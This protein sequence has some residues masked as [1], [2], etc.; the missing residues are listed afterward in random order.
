MSCPKKP[1]SRLESLPR[2]RGSDRRTLSTR[3]AI[4]CLSSSGK[5]PYLDLLYRSLAAAGVPAGPHAQLRLRWLLAHRESVRHLHV[6]WPEGLY[7]LRRGPTT[8]KPLLSWAKLTLLE[9]RLRMARVLGYRVIWTIHQ[10]YPHGEVRRIDRVAARLL[11]RHAALLVAHDPE[12]AA[13]ARAELGQGSQ[14]IE[15]VQHGSYVGVYPPGKPREAM[16]TALGVDARAVVFLCFGELREN[17]DVDVLLSAFTDVA[18]DSV[19]VV[20]GN[21]KDRDAGAAVAAASATNPRI[22][23]IAGFVASERV[24]E[25]YEAAD[26]AVVPRGDGGTSGSLILALSL[27]TPVVAADRPGYRRLIGDEAAGWLFKPNDAA[28]LRRALEA[29]ARDETERK[30]RASAARRAAAALDWSDAAA[31]FASVL[32]E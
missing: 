7:R 16:R 12:T 17:S 19:L 9:A 13:R 15:V 31:R 5:N 22:V 32:P 26:V 4:S 24:R 20:A 28:D 30:E 21:A 6:H 11:A 2:M 29:A 27:G 14:A 23:R 25:L 3:N 10:V 8:L 18:A 1:S